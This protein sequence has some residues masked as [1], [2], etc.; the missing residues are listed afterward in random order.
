MIQL[1][2]KMSE[3]KIHYKLIFD[4]EGE[5]GSNF[6]SKITLLNQRTQIS[7]SIINKKENFWSSVQDFT[8]T[9]FN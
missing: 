4:G 1:S 5:P 9:W 6:S 7:L 3:R 2:T 8:S